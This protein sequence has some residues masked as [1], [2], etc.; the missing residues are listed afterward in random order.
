[1]KKFFTF[2][3]MSVLIVNSFPLNINASSSIDNDILI[4]ALLDKRAEYILSENNEKINELD[5][6]L[7]SLGVTKLTSSETYQLFNNTEYTNNSITTYVTKPV[8]D[9]ITWFTSRSDYTYNGTTYE[10]QTLTA[11]ANSKNSNLT[12]TGTKVLKSTYDWKIG[13]MNAL[14]IVGSEIAGVIPGAS[15]AI[16][17]YDLLNPYLSGISK[18][19]SIVDIEASYTYS[20]ITTVRFKYIKIKGQSDTMQNLTHISTS[21]I[22]EVTTTVPTIDISTGVGNPKNISSTER[23]YTT[24]SA[25]NSNSKAINAYINSTVH[26]AYANKITVTGIE[27]KNI[28]IHYPIQPHSPA[29]VY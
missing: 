15:L 28:I 5:I 8:S 14:K 4:D 3:L 19:T 6:Q 25:Y 9:T 29:Q 26:K 1:M 2:L 17:V 11:Q 22:T 20:H 18:E 24:P 13:N 7:N 16:T 23:I 10:I 12:K 27:S 21:A